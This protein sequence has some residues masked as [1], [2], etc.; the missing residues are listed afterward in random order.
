M[1]IKQREVVI[2]GAGVSGS[3]T[4]IRLLKQGI[5]PLMIDKAIFPRE[6]VGEGLSPVICEY[7]K[8]LD[9]LEEINQGGF[10]KKVHCN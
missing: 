10:L 9:V 1:D 4:A 2:V 3:S 6:V 7:L 8:E 5:R